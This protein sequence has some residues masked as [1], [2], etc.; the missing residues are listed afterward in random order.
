MTTNVSGR[1]RRSTEQ[2]PWEIVGTIEPEGDPDRMLAQL[3]NLTA[4]GVPREVTAEARRVVDEVPLGEIVPAGVAFNWHQ[5][6]DPDNLL[7]ELIKEAFKRRKFRQA[8]ALGA[9]LRKHFTP[10]TA[11]HPGTYVQM[12]IPVLLLGAF[13]VADAEVQWTTTST[14]NSARGL[15]IT[16]AGVGYGKTVT[17]EVTS[18]ITEACKPGLAKQITAHLTVRVTPMGFAYKGKPVFDF[19]RAEIAD[20][21]PDELPERWEGSYTSLTDVRML[22]GPGGEVIDRADADTL[23]GTITAETTRSQELT[24]GLTAKPGGV[25]LGLK[26]ETRVSGSEKYEITYSLPGGHAYRAY[27]PKDR[28]GIVWTEYII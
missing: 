8:N 21:A 12:H 28:L 10:K 11:I 16:V 19:F 15:R 2:L 4:D 6:G 23:T 27:P 22:L 5:Y 7:A 14:S 24:L 1:P 9:W 13:D 3:S 20:P 25:P 17:R 26:L 18:T